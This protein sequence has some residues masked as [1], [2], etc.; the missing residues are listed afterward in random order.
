MM[1]SK[2]TIVDYLKHGS[3]EYRIL[4]CVAYK[5]KNIVGIIKTSGWSLMNIKLYDVKDTTTDVALKVS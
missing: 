3:S 2:S 1:S 4:F 5:M